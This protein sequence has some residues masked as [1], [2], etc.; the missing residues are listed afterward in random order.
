MVADALHKADVKLM[1]EIGSFLC[2]STIQWLE[3]KSDVKVI[4]VDPWSS[5]FAAT[6]ARYNGNSVFDP[7]FKGIEDR[8]AV[9][10]AVRKNGPHA[11]AVANVK[12]YGDRFVPVRSISPNVLYELSDLG[13]SPGLIYF[14]SNKVLDDLT[15]CE[16]LFPDA[17]L[18]GDDWTWGADL[19]VQA[20]VKRFCGTR[21]Y[22]VDAKRATWV[23]R[24]T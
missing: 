9:I 22:T 11:S 6:L 10:A 13:V 17:I 24:K 20:A 1:L 2:G 5:D 16:E 14:D 3:A 12:K 23:I 15:V 7:C 18:C 19:P 21:G 4:G 8:A